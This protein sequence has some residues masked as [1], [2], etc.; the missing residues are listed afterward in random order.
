MFFM[1]FDQN[2]SHIMVWGLRKNTRLREQRFSVDC[3][4]TFFCGTLSETVSLFENSRN[5]SCAPSTSRV[6][7]VVC[8]ATYAREY[9]FAIALLR[10]LEILPAIAFCEAAP[11]RGEFRQL[12]SKHPCSCLWRSQVPCFDGFWMHARTHSSARGFSE[13]FHDL[14]Y[15]SCF[16]KQRGKRSFS[17]NA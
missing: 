13:D 15:V 11:Q 14:V 4:N 9:V 5:S 7:C 6:S 1:I 8:S 17:L 12:V 3:E 2:R 16:T 10:I